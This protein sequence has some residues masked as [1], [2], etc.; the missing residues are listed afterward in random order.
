MRKI[1]T[2]PPICS[3]ILTLRGTFCYTLRMKIIKIRAGILILL[4][5]LAIPAF[6]LGKKDK[7]ETTPASEEP[8]IE[9]QHIKI[10]LLLDTKKANPKNHFNWNTKSD[11]YKDYFDAVSGASKAHSTKQFR[12][13]VLENGSKNMRTPKG[14]RNLC[15]F[16]V[17]SPDLLEK[18]GFRIDSDG[19]KLVISFT[20]REI[21]YRIESDEDGMISVPEGFFIQLPPPKQTAGD[22]E[23]TEAEKADSSQAK[24][25]QPASENAS[26]EKAADGAESPDFQADAP[27]PS[28]ATLFKGKLKAQLSQD[29]IFTLGGKLVLA[30]REEPKTKAPEESPKPQSEDENAPPAKADEAQEAGAETP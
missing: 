13:F 24:A 22:S 10:D 29:G 12:D 4:A 1:Y 26:A 27:S 15:L 18:D 25:E 20:H 17:A 19:K 30:K 2:I 16:A 7:T 11:S 21:A 28:L 5:F 3:I 8:K 9:K 14:L 6:A 23:Q